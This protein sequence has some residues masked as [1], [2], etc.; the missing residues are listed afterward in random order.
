MTAQVQRKLK[1]LGYYSGS[2]D[3]A[4]GPV[5]RAAIRGY[6]GEKGLEI[7]GTID[8]ALLGSMGL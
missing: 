3:G 5:T 6:Q 2:V 8:Q 1:N 7:T 4:I